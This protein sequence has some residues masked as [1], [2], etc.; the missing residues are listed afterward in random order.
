MQGMKNVMSP[1]S[2]STEA[3][4]TVCLPGCTLSFVTSSRRGTEAVMALAHVLMFLGVTFVYP[5][6]AFLPTS[7]GNVGD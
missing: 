7:Y 6:L 5:I 2:P 3:E 1:K 4:G